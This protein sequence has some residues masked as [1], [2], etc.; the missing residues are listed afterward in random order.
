M[1]AP[2]PRAGATAARRLATSASA[3]RPASLLRPPPTDRILPTAPEWTYGPTPRAVPLRKPPG[4]TPA[5]QRYSALLPPST[6]ELVIGQFGV[7][8]RDASTLAASPLLRWAEAAFRLPHGPSTR[9]DARFVD[10]AGYTNHVVTGYWLGGYDAWRAATEAW[11]A[12]DARLDEPGTW[13]EVLRVPPDRFESIY[14]LDYPGGL[15]ADAGVAL[16]PT[17][18]CGYYGAMRDR[19]V[20][21]DA[22]EA[23]GAPPARRKG[24]TPRGRWRVAV[25]HNTA[26]IRTAHTWS[27]MDGEQKADYD[28]KLAPPLAKG[29]GYLQAHPDACLSLRWATTTAADGALVPEKHATGYFATLGKMEDWSERHRTHAAIFSAAVGRY[30]FYGEKNQLRTWHE[31]CV[32]PDD[33]EQLFE[34]IGCHGDTGLLPYFDAKGEAAA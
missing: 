16:Y 24:E 11:W 14:W 33:R 6:S 29:M 1:P 21:N 8:A 2:L 26:V 31:V 5:V 22:L 10:G 34:Y 4:F 30:K 32:L 28:A 17:P 15:S 13:R 18:Y 3:S 19:L 7:Q 9:D 27:A 23:P 20:V 12:E 25:P